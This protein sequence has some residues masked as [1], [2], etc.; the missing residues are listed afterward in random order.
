MIDILYYKA[1][2]YLRGKDTFDK[3]L[4]HAV[5]LRPY[6]CPTDGVCVE[7]IAKSRGTSDGLTSF[8]FICIKNIWKMFLP[9][10]DDIVSRF[11]NSSEDSKYSARIQDCR[12]SCWR[13]SW[14]KCTMLLKGTMKKWTIYDCKYIP[15]ADL[16]PH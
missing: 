16:E 9:N 10:T 1:I 13:L 12:Y 7:A 11:K 4:L 3:Y 6:F 15:Q 8:Q 2:V 5:K 14:Y